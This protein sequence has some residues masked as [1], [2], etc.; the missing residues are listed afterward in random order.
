MSPISQ[1]Q[2]LLRQALLI[3]YNHIC[4]N[5]Y[6]N[7]IEGAIAEVQKWCD[8]LS[9]YLRLTPSIKHNP[10]EKD[11]DHEKER[12]KRSAE[13]L[14][15]SLSNLANPSS[16]KESEWV[17]LLSILGEAYTEHIVREEEW[18]A[19]HKNQSLQKKNLLLF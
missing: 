11:R 7:Q 13:A 16:W 19:S 18:I 9:H 1:T 2:L 17:L 4:M 6:D 8:A 5:Y 15:S 10:L 14:N 12:V 3:H